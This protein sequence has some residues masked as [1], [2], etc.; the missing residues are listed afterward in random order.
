MDTASLGRSA[1]KRIGTR[2]PRICVVSQGTLS[3]LLHRLVPQYRGRAE[4]DLID[5]TFENAVA[6]VREFEEARAVDVVVSAGASGAN[7]QRNVRTPVTLVRVSG[8]DLF[9]ALV[10]ASEHDRSVA[11]LT[12]QDV[13]P[14]LS[15]AQQ[16]IEIDIAER[17]YTSPADAEQTVRELVGAGQRV[18][19]GSSLVMDLAK[20]HGVTGIFIYSEGSVRTALDEAIRLAELSF[21][22][23]W[24]R[25]QLETVLARIEE[26]VISV[27]PREH[28][29]SINPRM[30]E[31]LGV[32]REW[33]VGK[34]LGDIAPSLTLEP[35][36]R[37]GQGVA[38][39]R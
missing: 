21:E 1:A 24:R 28:I 32:A 4:I 38:V 12:H 33:A 27:D 26:G 10:R 19:L 17:H 3:Q 37:R 14:E 13:G 36:L 15:E 39:G 11:L 16:L 35:T 7:L 34:K 6:R 25:A 29:Q 9:R 30:A 18:L 20:Q 23:E 8:F 2:V 5:A 31:I 22:E